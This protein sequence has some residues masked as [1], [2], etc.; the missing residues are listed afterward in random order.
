M[1]KI[2]FLR[3]AG[4]FIILSS[5]PLVLADSHPATIGQGTD[6]VAMQLHYPA[7]ERAAKT[8]GAVKFYCEVSSQGK[9]GHISTLY[10]KREGRFGTA[11]E[12]AL[13]HGRFTPA[14]I[15]GKPT[16]VMLGGTVLFMLASGQPTIAVALATAE[17][18]KITAMTNYVQPQMIDSDALFRRKIFALRDKYTLR[19]G[20]HPGAV[21][22][23]HVDAQG[24]AVSKKIATESPA[25]G[26]HGRLVLDVVDQEKFIP[27]LSN[28]RPV[29]GDFEL[30]VDFEHMQ[31]PDSGPRVGT[32]LKDD[33][34]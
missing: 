15:E 5:S 26:G 28:G 25:N 30:A 20:A 21:V 14:T 16:S 7:K 13:R 24:N 6:S 22:V 4:L 17:S 10:G 3:C 33:G 27:A 34:Y 23:V 29:A 18:D 32:L 2:V 9:A 12:Y 31:N 1:S 19:Y 11:V 8:E